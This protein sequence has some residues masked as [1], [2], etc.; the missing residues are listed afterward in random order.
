MTGEWRML[1]LFLKKGG[2]EKSRELLVSEVHVT[3][4]ETIG[5]SCTRVR[6]HNFLIK[7]QE[8][9]TEQ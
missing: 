8:F 4:R 2:R 3:G 7:C 6:V 5:E 1:F 9:E